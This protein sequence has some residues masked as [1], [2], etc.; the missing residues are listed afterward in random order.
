M[1]WKR[2]INQLYQTRVGGCEA[3]TAVTL[4]LGT[5]S[6]RRQSTRDPGFV[7][8]V[9]AGLPKA[10]RYH[11]WWVLR[12]VISTKTSTV[13]VFYRTKL[14]RK[15]DLILGKPA[16]PPDPRH[17]S[18]EASPNADSRAQ[19]T[20]KPKISLSKPKM[21]Q[22]C[23]AWAKNRMRVTSLSLDPYVLNS[24][25]ESTNRLRNLHRAKCHRVSQWRNRILAQQQERNFGRAY[26]CPLSDPLLVSYCHCNRM[27]FYVLTAEVVS[28][29]HNV[30]NSKLEGKSKKLSCLN[31]A[32]NNYNF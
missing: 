25:P 1:V 4:P 31:S 16:P 29:G 27:F 28:P 6:I 8:G 11:L 17:Q 7:K 12:P 24:G 20:R 15:G 19:G 9:V 3:F 21:A 2:P 10:S 13:G 18:E 14:A 5:H 30:V 32:M 26:M 22:R 23:L